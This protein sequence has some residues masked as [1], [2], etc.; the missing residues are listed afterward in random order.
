MESGSSG[1]PF[2]YASKVLKILQLEKQTLK[3]YY[4]NAKVIKM[5]FIVR[6]TYFKI[7]GET[8]SF[9]EE[10]RERIKNY[11]LEKIRSDDVEFIQK[12][13]YNFQI[14]I[15][16]VK[17]Y[18]Q[19]CLERRIVVEDE[20]VQCGYALKKENYCFQYSMKDYLD[21]D[22]MFYEDISPL[23]QNVSEESMR[24]WRYVFMEMMNNAIEHSGCKNIFCNVQKDVLYTE[25]SIADDGIGIFQKVRDYLTIEWGR[26]ANYQ[27][28]L[29]ELYKGKFTTAFDNHSGEGIF[30]SSKM[31]D[32]FAI[33]SDNAMLVQGVQMQ[34]QF[35]QNHLIAYYTRLQ[36]IGTAVVMKLNNQTERTLKEVFDMFATPDE[37][38]IKTRIPIKDVCQS[39]EPI[40]R[41]QA[42]RILNRL[43]Q[44]KVAEFDFDGVEF[45]GQG[46]ADEVF[47]VFK[48]SHPE[49]EIVPIN[50][51]PFVLRMIKH[52]QRTQRTP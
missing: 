25:I 2:S 37:G 17:R 46:F 12:T 50:A 28:A 38:F 10:K 14:S 16:T 8:M 23:L 15:T 26:S 21:E 24:I 51:C 33:W 22:S 1:L 7:R 4:K 6:K 18:I 52:V 20:Q 13:M 44:F 43:E 39:G 5:G 49:V 30:F 31:T 34:T 29:T 41:S 27:D 19:E 3:F 35:V 47:R 36:N 42:R 48:N 9:Q 40:A 45:M 11:M 32:K